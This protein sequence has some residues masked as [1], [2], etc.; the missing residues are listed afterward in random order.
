MVNVSLQCYS[1]P[2][3]SVLCFESDDSFEA[4]CAALSGFD[5]KRGRSKGCDRSRSH[6]QQVS[7]LA[8]TSCRTL[9][10]AA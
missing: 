10:G 7:A 5:G 8:P 1:V 6:G 9:G 3:D 4:V 2:M